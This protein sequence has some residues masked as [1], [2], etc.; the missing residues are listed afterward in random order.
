MAASTTVF[1]WID[2]L[3]L[4][5]IP[6]ATRADQLASFESLAPDGGPTLTSYL[7]YRDYRDHLKLL[8][9]LAVAYP[10]PVRIG[11][12]VHSERIWGQFV[13]G[14]FFSVL[15]VR[16]ASGRFFSPDEYG[17]KPGAY[18]VAVISYGLWKRDFHGEDVIGRT[19]RVNRMPLTIVGVAPPEFH[20]SISGL[21]FE[22]WTPLMMAADMNALP[23][24]MLDDR[25]SRILWSVARLRP[26]VTVAQA[27]T[28]ASALAA[29]MARM[30]A[31]TNTG[32]GATLLPLSKA[33]NGAQDTLGSPLRILMAVCCLVLLIACANVANL[34]LAR[35]SGRGQELSIRIALGAGRFR[36]LRQMLTESLFLSLLG[37]L[38]AGP[39]TMWMMHSLGYLMPPG[40]LPT[41]VD[42][43]LD[44]DILA[45]TAIVCVLVSLA[46]GAI[47][48]LYAVRGG[49]REGLAA[50]G[51][52][53]TSGAASARTRGLLVSAEVGLAL[54]AIIGA[55][56]FTRSF[57][58]AARVN[59]GFDPHHVLVSYVDLTTA[60]YSVP[61]RR[62][63]SQ[64]L[65]ERLQ[66]QPGVESAAYADIVPLGYL[67]SWEELQVEGYVPAQ[68]ESMNTDRQVVSPGYLTV[69]RIPLL[70]GRDF[71]DHDDDKSNPVMIVNQTFV[72]R[73]FGRRYPIGAHVRG[74]G[75]RFTVVGVAADS[76]YRRPTE[77]P[78]PFFYVPFRQISRENDA[79]A[80]LVRTSGDAASALRELRGTVH[81]L[82]PDVALY[83][84]GPLG[85]FIAISLM[86]QRAAAYLIGALGSIALLLAALGLYS[87]MA[88][89]VAQRR[90]EIAIRMA[91]GAKAS[92]VRALVVRQG[93]TMAVAGLLVGIAA[94]AAVTRVAAGLL[95]G[96]SSTDPTIFGGAAGFLAVVALAACYLPARRAT[97]IDPNAAL[98]QQ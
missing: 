74:W 76:K 88:Y 59:P 83:D 69:L 14:N 6:G 67:Y 98:R 20:G 25:H 32:V 87:V 58:I 70:D 55:A 22:M 94:A 8:S 16:P 46:A 30:D 57:Q 23:R 60:G 73:Y 75:R 37:A 91:L 43:R 65:R 80:F 48:A 89:T 24:W 50:G 96:V 66:T 44:G 33:H 40:D 72:R 26:G 34:L 35:G 4:H 1:T 52:T 38:A 86:P 84:S 9:G 17:D 68:G 7:D 63:F 95:F 49:V 97:L 47:P 13:S 27:R 62:Q 77:E 2:A 93:M 18:P 12:G 51:R 90:Q 5:P 36:L 21:S 45:F 31:D 64:G 53:G 61:K 81:S 29:R 92:D 56:L 19:I 41:G 39:L 79:I 42:I 10:N 82:D 71:T 85:D 11:V 28:E 78:R 54:V 15:G 3:V